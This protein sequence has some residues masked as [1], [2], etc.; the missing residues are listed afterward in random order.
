MGD[1][2]VIGYALVTLELGTVAAHAVVG[3]RAQPVLHRSLVRHIDVDFFQL[4]AV[5]SGERQQ[6]Q[7]R[8]NECNE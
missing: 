1:A 7:G 8:K 4:W 5:F 6:R 2:Q 3:E